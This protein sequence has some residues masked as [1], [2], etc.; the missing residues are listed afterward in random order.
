[1]EIISKK[2]KDIHPYGKNPRKNK[3]S[4]QYVAASIR[5]FGF[6][7]PIVIDKDGTIAAGHTR[8]LAAKQLQLDEV[9]CIIAD[10]L[11]DEQIKA[12]RLADNKVSE[13]SEW[14]VDLLAEE[15]DALLDLDMAEYG[16]DDDFRGEDDYE[17]PKTN[18]RERTGNTYNLDY[19]DLT[20]TGKWD[21]P[22]IRATGH[23]PADLISFNYVLSTHH[24]DKGVHFY[25]DDYQFERIWSEPETYIQ[26]LL[27]YD[28]VLT[29]DFSLYAEMPLPMQMWNVYRSRL[30]GQI[31]QDEGIEVIPTL[32]WC[33]ED[34]FD[35][36]FEGI[37]PGGVVSVSTIGVKRD[38]D[39][40]DLFEAGM[41]EA[42]KRLNPSHVV[43]YG[44]DTGYPFSCPVTYIT[45]HNADKLRGNV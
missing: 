3:E 5:D 25:I 35:F 8:Y 15:L 9:P 29:P 32:Q 14:D 18:E 13:F 24:Y 37:E 30:I 20:R 17:E 2:I 21:M 41:K 26:K 42:E 7:V 16:F 44:G 11:T 23:I 31:M 33:R 39:A 43:V 10:D 27:P 45:N 19:V 28:C 6:K 40:K 34:S 1:M 4:V 36:C 22:I 12:F 38:K